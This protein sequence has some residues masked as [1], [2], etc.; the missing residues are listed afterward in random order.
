ML[1]EVFGM[2]VKYHRIRQG[3]TQEEAAARCEISSEYLRKIECGKQAATLDT[4]EKIS[5]GLNVMAKDLLNET[6]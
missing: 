1:R 6:S 2:N 4:I 3:L 5:T